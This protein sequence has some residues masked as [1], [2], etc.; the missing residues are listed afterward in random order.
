MFLNFPTWPQFYF[1]SPIGLGV[2]EKYLL[3]ASYESKSRNEALSESEP[4]HQAAVSFLPGPLA[5]TALGM[6]KQGSPPV[7]VRLQGG[8]AV[9]FGGSLTWL[10]SQL[11]HCL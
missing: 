10:K 2:A 8:G 3:G 7:T 11:R 4:V 9:R 1:F 6:W 5:A